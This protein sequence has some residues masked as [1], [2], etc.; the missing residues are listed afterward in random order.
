MLYNVFVLQVSLNHSHHTSCL[1][2]RNTPILEAKAFGDV[3]QPL[4][5]PRVVCHCSAKVLRM[6]NVQKI[7][8]EYRA[9]HLAHTPP[10]K[11]SFK[12]DLQIFLPSIR[13]FQRR[14]K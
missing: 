3:D 5:P 1:V 7:R 4:P 2:R 13:H 12:I 10:S 14:Q 9:G 6:I 11:C 8:V